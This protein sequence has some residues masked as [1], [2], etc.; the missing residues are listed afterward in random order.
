MCPTQINRSALETEQ[1]KMPERLARFPGNFFGT[2]ESYSPVA[3]WLNY[4]DDVFIYGQ[5]AKVYRDHQAELVRAFPTITGWTPQR[6]ALPTH[7][8]Y[9]QSL[10]PYFR[11]LE[12]GDA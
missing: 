6:G 8:K 10:E 7:G 11:A 1:E 4:L 12:D 2:C 9:G 5:T 3:N